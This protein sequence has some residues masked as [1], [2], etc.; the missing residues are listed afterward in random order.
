MPR[1]SDWVSEAP[2]C[3]VPTRIVR[4]QVAMTGVIGYTYFKLKGTAGK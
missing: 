4:V 3:T 1:S 2:L